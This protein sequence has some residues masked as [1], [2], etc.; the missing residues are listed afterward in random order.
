MNDG[1]DTT[2]PPRLRLVGTPRLD[3]GE[4][5]LQLDEVETLLFAILVLDG[6]TARDALVSD[7]WPATK[8]A[9]PPQVNLRKQR[10]KHRKLFGRD[11][12]QGTGPG[13]KVVA[14]APDLG[15]DLGFLRNGDLS[16][17]MAKGPLFGAFGFARQQGTRG[18]WIERQREAARL[19]RMT[20]IGRRIDALEVGGRLY[21]AL[22]VAM[23]MVQLDPRIEAA[24]VAVARL[25]L[26]LGDRPGAASALHACR[27]MLRNELDAVPGPAV[28]ELEARLL[29]APLPADR[30]P[31]ALPIAMLHPRRMLCREREQR[32]IEA[33][34]GQGRPVHVEGEPGIGKSTLLAALRR[35]DRVLL[36][37]TDAA[38]AE[39]YGAL[40]LLL[41]AL[42]DEG[43]AR[44]TV[45]TRSELARVWPPLGP[46]SPL[47]MLTA[48]FEA[49]VAEAL[50][51][52]HGQGLAAVLVDD[53]QK[54]DP[55]SLTLLS[56][57]QQRRPGPT[58]LWA[59]RRGET[60][61]RLRDSLADST[62]P[63]LSVEL[64]SFDVPT[65]QRFLD[66][67][68]PALLDAPA[69]AAELA[70]HRI[71]NPLH[72]LQIVAEA[73]ERGGPPM[74]QS[75]PSLADQPSTALQAVLSRRIDALDGDARELA[76]LVALAGGELSV[77]LAAEAIG[78]QALAL[79]PAW[80]RLED[81]LLLQGQRLTH[82]LLREALLAAV[83]RAI[84][85]HQCAALAAA[86]ARAGL[87]PARIARLWLAAEEYGRAAAVFEQAATAAVVSNLWHEAHA[88]WDETAACHDQQGDGD[89]AFAARASAFDAAQECLAPAAL[90][91]RA[92]ELAQAARSDGQRFD[93]WVAQGRAAA[94]RA[95]LP[96]MREAA[97]RA[98]Q[99]CAA[100]PAARRARAVHLLAAAEVRLGDPPRALKLITAL[101][102]EIEAEGDRPARMAHQATLGHVAALAMQTDLSVSAYGAALGHAQAL[103]DWPEIMTI[104]Q[105]LAMVLSRN[106][107]FR[108]AHGLAQ[109]AD[110]MRLRLGDPPSIAT[111]ASTISLGMIAHRLGH[112]GEAL[113]ALETARQR[114]EAFGTTRWQAMAENHLARVYLDLGRGDLALA[115]LQTPWP[116]DDATG[117]VRALV[118]IA[119]TATDQ[120][121]R[122]ERLARL[123]ARHVSTALPERH[124]VELAWIAECPPQTAVA[125]A[126]ALALQCE[127]AQFASAA[128]SARLLQ[129]LALAESGRGAEG[130]T[131]L[132][133][134]V[135]SL[136]ERMPSPMY[137]GQAWWIVHRVY[138]LAGRPADAAAALQRGV[139]WVMQ[140]HDG[141]VPPGHRSSF[142]SGNP[143][144]RQLMDTAAAAR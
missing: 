32:E 117:I 118:E 12:L 7:L 77:E 91:Q 38:A 68:G 3:L 62:P 65:T 139:A 107:E 82:D 112:C 136:D 28:R 57:V 85:L 132:A 13:S 86:A 142:L 103:D 109:A 124:A 128:R 89:G 137:F 67:L 58:W 126:A 144:N 115:A 19:R 49:A 73:F 11:F 105:S 120:T 108:R 123:A 44:C 14:L 36:Q 88:W 59:S 26:R 129:A 131:L 10:E 134:F 35:G 2:T 138:H 70:R 22:D 119:C 125:A 143:V 81:A 23:E 111:A 74:L 30:R 54:L 29:R 64:V 34:L 99:L 31:G 5:S 63:G 33:A 47:P 101:G 110:A 20:I 50:A 24:H 94:D 39:P 106:G 130:A 140:V 56:R 17:D 71:G 84:A 83:P 100:M 4:R 90:Q 98:V 51:L 114:F 46:V 97:E 116:G 135:D 27:E 80:S 61:Q 21:E 104:C 8:S 48:R 9:V 72:V 53:A 133:L 93:A 76:F 41:A 92:A 102:P 15:H 18:P 40:R 37:V 69:W 16:G 60:P 55:G 1:R 78:R 45:A 79:V 113:Q 95:D 127:A 42:P 87:A 121:E 43:L 52:A 25:C 75:P 122:A 96:A 6:P 66:G 141:H